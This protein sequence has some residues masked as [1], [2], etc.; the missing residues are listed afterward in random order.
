[1][2][3]KIQSKQ[4]NIRKIMEQFPN[5][6]IIKFHVKLFFA[7]VI[8]WLGSWN[9]FWTYSEETVVSKHKIDKNSLQTDHV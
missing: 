4:S 8:S 2:Q 6:T 9:I 3:D 1:M 5:V 7:T